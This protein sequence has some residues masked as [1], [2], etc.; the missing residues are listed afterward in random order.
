MAPLCTICLDD[1]APIQFECGTATCEYMLCGGCLEDAFN[2]FSGNNNKIC[3][4]CKRPS[5]ISMAEA[6][7]GKGGVKAVQRELRE[8]VEVEL[9]QEQGLY[10]ACKKNAEETNEEALRLFNSISEKL[11][12]TCPRCKMAFSDYSGCNALTCA[13]DT[14]NCKFC[15]I[16]LKD[17]GADAHSHVRQAHGNLFDRNMFEETTKER[18]RYIIETF[19]KELESESKPF[20]LRQLVKNHLER[21]GHLS[22]ADGSSGVSYKASR[23][24]QEATRDLE[25]VIASDRRSILVDRQ[26]GRFGRDTITKDSISPRAVIPESIR[27][28]LRQDNEDFEIVVQADIEGELVTADSPEQVKEWIKHGLIPSSGSL[29]T[30]KQSLGCAIIAIENF[31]TLYQVRRI[32]NKEGSSGVKLNFSSID[33]QGNIEEERNRFEYH[34][35]RMLRVLAINPNSRYLSLQ[36]HIDENVTKEKLPLALKHFIGVGKPHPVFFQLTSTVPETLNKLNEDQLKA[37]HPLY[38]KS[39]GEVAGPPGTGQFLFCVCAMPLWI[40]I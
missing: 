28:W 10:E 27:V 7:I 23:F 30:L 38:L 33:K 20:E 5:A 11:N 19:L 15:A 24:I 37:G 18:S 29:A 16:C 2:D 6:R 13:N 22:Q 21:A 9:R 17:C 36:K 14:C 32:T 3:Q 12:L 25:Q 40:K 34:E 39:A 31:R 1:E 35:T 26:G 4:L 8:T